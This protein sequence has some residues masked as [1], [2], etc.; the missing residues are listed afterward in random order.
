MYVKS[1]SYVTLLKC[2]L[3]AVVSI[4]GKQLRNLEVEETD[5]LCYK[6]QLLQEYPP[7]LS[8]KRPLKF[9]SFKF[10]KP[11]NY[12]SLTIKF[13]SPYLRIQLLKHNSPFLSCTT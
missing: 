12:L 9:I 2:Y 10:Q 13:N 7:L 11:E 3:Q 8:I 5:P 4:S 6:R 1:E